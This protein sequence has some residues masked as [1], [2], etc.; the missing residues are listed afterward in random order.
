MSSLICKFCKNI[1]YVEFLPGH[2]L[3][4]SCCKTNSI[5]YLDIE[6]E[7][8]NNY[9]LKCELPC[10][11][12][13]STVVS[14][15]LKRVI[16][17]DCLKDFQS[18]QKKKT[19]DSYIINDSIPYTCK[20]HYSK[21]IYYDESNKEYFC[22]SCKFFGNKLL[23]YKDLR[24][25]YEKDSFDF[26]KLNNSIP[27]CFKKLFKIL[28]NDYEKY[29]KN[30]KVINC[31]FN[32]KN[33]KNYIEEYSI[34]SPICS[35]C[36]KLYFIKIDRDN[37]EN[38]IDDKSN[39]LLEASCQCQTNTFHSIKEFEEYINTIKCEKCDDLFQQKDIFYD[40]ICGKLFCFKCMEEINN[41]DFILFNEICYIC[42]LHKNQFIYYCKKCGK[43]LCKECNNCDGHE[44]IL[45][46]DDKKNKK[47][48]ED[49]IELDNLNWFKK[50]KNKG[51]L[52]LG[53]F[54]K[55]C[56]N[57]NNRE[58]LGLETLKKKIEEK[59]DLKI[60]MDIKTSLFKSNIFEI[61]YSELLTNFC[62][63]KINTSKKEL[64]LK[65]MIQKRKL[66]NEALFKELIIKNDLVYILKLRN[67]LQS[68]I[69]NFIKKEYI[70]LKPIKED[71]RILYESYKFLKYLS[72]NKNNEDKILLE[73]LETIALKLE[74]LIKET[75]K[76]VCLQKFMN[77]FK[78]LNKTFNYNIDEK[79]IEKGFISTNNIKNNFTNIVNEITPKIPFHEK[80]KLFNLVFENKTKND[81]DKAKFS[82]ICEYNKYLED[83]NLIDYESIKGITIIVNNLEKNKVPED[84]DNND[85]IKYVNI[86]ENIYC[87]KNGYINDNSFNKESI[88][89]I[90]KN[91]NETK[92]Q[93]LRIKEEKKKEILSKLNLNNEIDFNFI[94]TLI[95]NLINRIS[96]IIH[97]SDSSFIFLF[98][99][100]EKE[101]LDIN[102][103]QLTKD[104]KSENKFKFIDENDNSEAYKNVFKIK[105]YK[106]E[107]FLKF[108]D[109]FTKI[110]IKEIK[111]IMN[112]KQ[113]NQIIKD[114]EME[115]KNIN[116]KDTIKNGF[117]TLDEILKE[118]I[119][120]YTQYRELFEY[121]PQ[122][123][124]DINIIISDEFT[125]DVINT[126]YEKYSDLKTKN[127]ENSFINLF[128]KN[129]LL[130]IYLIRKIK[131]A[132]KNYDAICLN[133]N[134]LL[135]EYVN[136]RLS[137][138][139]LELFCKID[140]SDISVIFQ[141]E[142]DNLI[143]DYKN[144]K[145]NLEKKLKE[146]GNKNLED[147]IKAYS[148]TINKM[149]NIKIKSISTIFENYFDFEIS[150]FSNTKFDVFLYLYQNNLIHDLNINN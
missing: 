58:N 147:E 40:F 46:E 97:Q 24:E 45:F 2:T 72:N 43:F 71:F 109:D 48:Q 8:E 3:K 44:L 106:N 66:V 15:Y 118:G 112:K 145:N 12:Q 108:A 114:S 143:L 84:L 73:K 63:Y 56:S 62:E 139:V 122:I 129:Y 14:Y 137:E 119:N 64:D 123:I 5:R 57:E 23:Q 26:N 17:E 100:I 94:L 33:L 87:D 31:Y 124:E 75:I 27:F 135:N 144:T 7:I 39:Y 104:N 78:N 150:S 91:A 93:S 96:K 102:R 80:L 34:I 20:R 70:S 1:P 42:C 37:S 53:I 32:I 88:N 9:T 22:T 50:L 28:K 99:D 149:N 142:R 113:I 120:F 11:M 52:N 16:C 49:F 76:K 81:I 90:L 10:C 110:N 131:I 121:F 25:K 103:Y 18:K 21:Y 111:K 59:L 83:K 65:K 95:I 125:P 134:E 117:N 130:I 128:V 69:F 29:G 30:F 132:R 38:V 47:F 13:K 51:C 67:I 89:E 54:Q 138:K 61:K 115:Y 127:D 85:F 148:L 107:I 35:I 6:N 126:Y 133:L 74:E 36:K 105:K 116:E 98:N 141:T 92:Y 136:Y 19:T 140:K 41:L 146:N 77:N 60:F 86:T 68:L 79:I 101:K 4:F 55:Y 82:T